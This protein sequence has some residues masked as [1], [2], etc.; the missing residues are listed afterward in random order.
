MLVWSASLLGL[1]ELVW[2][3]LEV[4]LLAA[5]SLQEDWVLDLKVNVRNS[6][7]IHVNKSF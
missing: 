6:P 5:R 1:L 3:G 2:V 7:D 4:G